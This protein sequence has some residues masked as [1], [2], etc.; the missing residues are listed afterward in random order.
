VELYDMDADGTELNDPAPRERAGQEMA[1]QYDARANECS[2]GRRL[3][4]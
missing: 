4:H 2:T 3:W 1:A